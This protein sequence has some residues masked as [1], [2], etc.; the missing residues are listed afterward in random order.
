MAPPFALPEDVVEFVN[1]VLGRCNTRIA[2]RLSRLPTIHETCR[3]LRA[4]DLRPQLTGRGT[5]PQATVTCEKLSAART[6]MVGIGLAGGLRHLSAMRFLTV[7]RVMSPDLSLTSTLDCSSL[8]QRG[9]PDFGS[10]ANRHQ[11]SLRCRTRRRG[12]IAG[13]T[14]PSEGVADS[15]TKGLPISR[16]GPRREPASRM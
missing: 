11:C 8:S 7:G 12:A 5:M 1:K 14:V 2:S 15:S 3:V 13:S 16:S 4:T 6:V 10:S 9:A